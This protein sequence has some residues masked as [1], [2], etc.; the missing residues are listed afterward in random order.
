MNILECK[1]QL[2][3]LRNSFHDFIHFNYILELNNFKVR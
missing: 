3:I 2:Y 1:G